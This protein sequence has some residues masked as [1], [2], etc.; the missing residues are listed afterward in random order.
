MKGR[1]FYL[2]ST[3]NPLAQIL[4]LVVLAGVAVIA[5][6]MG[7]FVFLAFL[8]L[9]ALGLVV[10][11]VRSWW[12]RRKLRGRGPFDGGTEPPG[13]AKGARLIEGEFI[14]V[15]ADADAARRKRG[16]H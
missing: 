10:F 16:G 13:P 4:S 8:G 15:E 14:V 12:W 1:Q 2:G 11:A 6:V 9:A 5:V 3:G 7:A